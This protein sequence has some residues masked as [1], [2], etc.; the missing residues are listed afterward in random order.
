MS[1]HFCKFFPMLFPSSQED[2]GS[3]IQNECRS[4]GRPSLLL[5]LWSSPPYSLLRSWKRVQVF[6]PRVMRLLPSR[7]T[8]PLYRDMRC[9]S[10]YS[11]T[12]KPVLS[13]GSGYVLMFCHVSSGNIVSSFFVLFQE[14][15]V[16]KNYTPS[17]L[18]RQST[19][20]RISLSGLCS[21][22]DG[23]YNTQDV[24]IG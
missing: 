24:S 8:D 5:S 16:S 17:Y 6:C 7:K 9:R 23:K 14:I 4:E 1:I 15:S 18:K 3:L 21:P 22:Q 19:K 12:K 2:P 13:P 20:N 10:F 11:D